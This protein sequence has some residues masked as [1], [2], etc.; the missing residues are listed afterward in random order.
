M[1]NN[2]DGAAFLLS[3]SISRCSWDFFQAIYS[4][5]QISYAGYE[6]ILFKC[7]T[8]HRLLLYFSISPGSLER[9]SPCHMPPS[10]D[11]NLTLFHTS[12][13]LKYALHYSNILFCHWFGAGGHSWVTLKKETKGSQ[14]TLSRLICTLRRMDRLFQLINLGV[15]GFAVCIYY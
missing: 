4:L 5:I 10:N 12:M 9:T 11:K 2:T 15:Y 1:V 7:V 3:R 13:H 6:L 8:L 14:W